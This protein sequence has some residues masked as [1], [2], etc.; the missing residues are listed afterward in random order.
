MDFEK[1][2]EDVLNTGEVK[3]GSN[4]TIKSLENEQA[5][6]VIVASNCPKEI[7]E[8][9][10]QK[11]KEAGTRVIETDYQNYELGKVCGRPHTVASLSITDA[12]D[13][14]ILGLKETGGQDE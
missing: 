11:S 9:I 7:N 1:A 8:E 12:G 2:I 5:E 14:G 13:S 6:L 10:N 4:E 3:I